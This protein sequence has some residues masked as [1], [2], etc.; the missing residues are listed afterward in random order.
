MGIGGKTVE[1]KVDKNA[2]ITTVSAAVQAEFKL[3]SKPLLTYSYGN[4]SIALMDEDG[5]ETIFS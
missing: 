4:S 5:T 1:V 3:A 2:T